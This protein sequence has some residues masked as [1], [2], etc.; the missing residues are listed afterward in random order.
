MRCRPTLAMLAALAMTGCSL[1][2]VKGPPGGH[3]QMAE[4]SCTENYFIPVVEAVS[5]ASLLTVGVIW[6]AESQSERGWA[7]VPIGISLPLGA[8]SV[9]GFS[10]VSRCRDALEALRQ[11]SVDGYP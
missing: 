3:E 9:G 6:I 4:F 8:S 10:R 7:V 1:A 2:M 11:R 5:A